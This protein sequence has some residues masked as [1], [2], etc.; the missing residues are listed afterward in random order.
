MKTIIENYLKTYTSLN[1]ECKKYLLL[2]FVRSYSSGIIFYIAIYLANLNLNANV[3]GYQVSSLVL[4]NLLGSLFASQILNNNNVLKLAGFSLFI[5]GLS[6][7]VISLHA[8]VYILAAAVFFVGFSGYF[9]QVAS[10][11]IITG[12]SGSDKGSRSKAITLI[13]VFSNLG[14]SLGGVSVSLFSENHALMLFLST[15][16]LLM[17]IAMP[18]FNNNTHIGNLID[19]NINNDDSP[20]TNFLLLSLFAIMITGMIFAQQR[21]GFGIFLTDHFS[22]S[23]MSSIILINSMMIIFVLPTLRPMLIKINSVITMGVGVLL[24]GGGMFF[25]QYITSFYFVALLCVIW[26]LGEMIASTLSHLIC[27]QFSKKDNRGKA[28]G[29]Y[30]FL[31]AFGTFLGAIIGA[32]LLKNYSINSIWQLCGFLGFFMLFLSVVVFNFNRYNFLPNKR[33][34]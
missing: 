3:I 11:F 18:Y 25:L 16:L 21:V 13:S 6:F 24:L 15:G 22:G 28:M 31:Y 8:S 27:F 20:E 23:G 26:T 10:S 7:G 17:I 12:L 34:L 30:K 2:Y 32:G 29:L 5:Q 1:D 33:T 9:Y 19:N 14:L 4:G